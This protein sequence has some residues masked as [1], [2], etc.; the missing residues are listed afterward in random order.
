MFFSTLS[1]IGQNQSSWSLDQV[2]AATGNG[3]PTT[4]PTLKPSQNN[5]E[6]FLFLWTNGGGWSCVGP[7]PCYDTDDFPHEDYLISLSSPWQ[8][9]PIGDQIDMPGGIQPAP[10]NIFPER[11]MT[12]VYNFWDSNSTPVGVNATNVYD[13]TIIGTN[14]AAILALIKYQGNVAVN[15]RRLLQLLLMRS[16]TR[17]S[18]WPVLRMELTIILDS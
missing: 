5:E 1:A 9:A 10:S 12:G 11:F 14:W 4:L 13:P 2:V 15:G 6:A 7:L 17:R 18:A 16:I 8:T 3:N